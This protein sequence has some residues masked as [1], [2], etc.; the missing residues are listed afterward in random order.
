[1]I[2]TAMHTSAATSNTPLRRAVERGQSLHGCLDQRPGLAAVRGL[3]VQEEI[4][5]HSYGLWEIFSGDKSPNTAST[6]HGGRL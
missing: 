3:L 1:M 5:A 4:M 2:A 6:R